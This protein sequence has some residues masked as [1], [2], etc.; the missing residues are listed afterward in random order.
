MTL[1]I[2]VAMTSDRVIGKDNDLPWRLPEDLKYF[3]RVTMG[4]P[5]IMGRKTH[6][7][8]GRALPGRRN[9]VLSRDPNYQPAK[10]CDLVGSLAQA[11]EICA[12]AEEVF[13]IGGSSSFAEALPAADRLYLTEVHE[14]VEGDT[15]FPEFDTEAWKEVSREASV[16]CS[17]TV[18]ERL[19]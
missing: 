6:E 14:A 9:I 16:G 2:I 10:G 4:M 7:S 15:W 3:K 17:F 19:S 13:V 18:L 8:I 5:I 11:I 1:S 12:D